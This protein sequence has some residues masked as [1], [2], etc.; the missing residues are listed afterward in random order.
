MDSRNKRLN[1][2]SKLMCAEL[3]LQ[4]EEKVKLDILNEY[5]MG[6][7]VNKHLDNINKTKK[8]QEI[9]PEG[10]TST[11]QAIRDYSYKEKIRKASGQY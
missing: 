9:S 1:R 10:W 6:N 8:E 2:I 7:I 4:M 5:V 11:L 3:Y